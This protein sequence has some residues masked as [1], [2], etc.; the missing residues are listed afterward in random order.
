MRVLIKLGGALLDAEA[1]RRRLAKELTEAS[2][3]GVRL[4]VVHGGGKQMT[5]FL[6]ERGIESRFIEGLR[7]TT[8]EVLEA[9]LQVLGGSVNQELVAA[10]IEA[11]ARAV[12]LS[13]VDACLVEAE[14][15]GAALGAVGRPVRSNPELLELL[16]SRRYVP[17]VACVAG[18]RQGRIYNVNADQMAAAC[19]V[20]FAAE[21][22]VFLTDV[23]GVLDSRGQ[24]LPVL[25][26][27]ESQALIEQGVASGGMLA[28]LKAAI[29]AVRQGVQQVVIAPGAEPNI[30]S[31]LLAGESV[32]S[33]L[34]RGPV[35]A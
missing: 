35:D 11:G 34:V 13:G 1:S 14:S 31:R 16:T 3:H 5:R 29:Q 30:V 9:V 18:D 32:G 33:R 20:G 19:A 6:A 23:Q 28:K 22:L 2:E 8:P 17:V 21:R 25:T 12:G 26:A 7:V 15:M 27:A 4:V 24:T 10:F